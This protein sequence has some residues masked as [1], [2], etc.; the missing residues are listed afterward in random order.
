LSRADAP[1][2]R[3][4]ENRADFAAFAALRASPR[5]TEPVFPDPMMERWFIRLLRVLRAL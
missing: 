2:L 4:E 1:A 3:A 5:E